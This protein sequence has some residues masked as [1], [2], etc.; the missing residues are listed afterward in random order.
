MLDSLKVGWV[1]CS[2]NQIRINPKRY[3]KYYLGYLKYS[4]QS[5]CAGRKIQGKNF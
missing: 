5:E 1:S 4:G 3:I 2:S